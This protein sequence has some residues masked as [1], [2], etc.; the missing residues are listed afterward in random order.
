M[1]LTVLWRWSRCCSYS[2]WLCGLYY[3]VFHVLKS[4][5]AL[6]PRVS[7][8][9]LALWLPRLGKR[10]LVYVLLVYLLVC[11]ARVSF[12]PLSLPIGVGVCCGLWLSHGLDCSINF[13]TM[14][15][16]KIYGLFRY[17]TRT[18]KKYFIPLRLTRPVMQWERN[19]VI[20]WWDLGILTHISL[21][22]Y[23]WAIGKQ[24]RPE[25]AASRLGLH[26][27]LTGISIKM[28]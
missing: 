1:L 13:F 16:T 20:S 23:F 22:S 21:A 24:Y 8:F 25:N 2:V 18:F 15:R 5:R 10:E 4:S 6:C 9:L 28:K 27:L 7:S 12:C 26:C 14:S 11:F 17:L 3:G 19:S